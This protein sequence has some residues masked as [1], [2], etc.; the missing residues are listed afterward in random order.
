MNYEQAE[1]WLRAI[2]GTHEIERDGSGNE[3][4]V[5]RLVSATGG[6]VSRRA[7]IDPALAGYGPGEGVRRALVLAC[8]E[9]KL[10]LG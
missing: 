4:V 7:T 2:G 1:R 8:E 5:V 6:P 3:V 10:A 9:L